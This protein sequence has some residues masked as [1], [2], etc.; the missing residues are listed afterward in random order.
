ME[1]LRAAYHHDG[2]GDGEHTAFPTSQPAS[3]YQGSYLGGHVPVIL[4]LLP[5]VIVLA[6]HGRFFHIYLLMVVVMVVLVV[7]VL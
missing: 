6:N 7:L 3:D 5:M 2:Q 4:V 1:L